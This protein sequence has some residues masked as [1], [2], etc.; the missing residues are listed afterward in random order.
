APA[1]AEITTSFCMNGSDKKNG[2][3]ITLGSGTITDISEEEGTII[4]DKFD[5]AQNYP[6]PFNPATTLRYSLPEA[7][8][9]SIK[10]YNMLG[11]LVKELVNDDVSAGV[12][13]VQWNGDDES[14]RK[15]SSGTYIYRVVAGKNVMTKKM[16][17]LK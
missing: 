11:Q 12:F 5:V 8:F 2:P 14:G 1:G 6:N 16:V 9:V 7:T 17:L 13:E 15:V 10:I 4:P 3:V